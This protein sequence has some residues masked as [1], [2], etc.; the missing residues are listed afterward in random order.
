MGR[1]A[2]NGLPK[3]RAHLHLEFNVR[4]S[5]NFRSWYDRQK[6]GTRNYHGIYNGFNFIGWDSLDFYTAYRSGEIKT[7]AEYLRAIP[8]GVVA[9]VRTTA[10]PWFIQRN[11]ALL[12]SAIPAEGVKGWRV[13]FTQFGLPKLWTP[14]AEAPRYHLSLTEGPAGLCSCRKMIAGAHTPGKDLR[15]I[16]ELL[17]GEKF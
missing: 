15:T 4:L 5:N 8:T 12:A 14:L 7:V 10:V 6:F 9:E 17:F 16:L 1:S 3:E 11:S 13:E 2:A